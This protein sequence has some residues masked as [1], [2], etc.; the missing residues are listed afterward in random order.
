MEE[1]LVPL[2]HLTIPKMKRSDPAPL[3]V[4]SSLLREET[5]RKQQLVDETRDRLLPEP[6]IIA[7]VCISLV[8]REI[9]G[10]GGWRYRLEWYK[11]HAP[12]KVVLLLCTTRVGIDGGSLWDCDGTIGK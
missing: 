3:A 1:K 2:V 8:T 12:L 10:L 4:P 6:W 9:T 7:G 5:G 11:S